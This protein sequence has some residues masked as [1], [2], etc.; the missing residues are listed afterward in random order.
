[1]KAL[2][3]M[4]NFTGLEDVERWIDRFELAIEIDEQQDKHGGK[5]KD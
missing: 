2:K 5:I 1:M 3:K 4:G